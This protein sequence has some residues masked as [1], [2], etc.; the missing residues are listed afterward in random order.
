MRSRRKLLGG[1]LTILLVAGCALPPSPEEQARRRATDRVR[2]E[3]TR[4]ATSVWAGLQAVD[5]GGARR[6]VEQHE[7]LLG[8]FDPAAGPWENGVLAASVEEDGTVRLDLAFRD[9]ADAGGGL[10][11]ASVV[12]MLC[13]RLTGTAGPGGQVRLANLAC[14]PGSVTAGLVDE[15]VTLAR[16]GPPPAPEPPRRPCRSGDNGQCP[17]G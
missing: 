5:A 9:Q 13:V 3:A 1:L 15:V 10:A 14:P 2:A 12:V 8:R 16:E 11:A 7:D 17:G 6:V 4:L